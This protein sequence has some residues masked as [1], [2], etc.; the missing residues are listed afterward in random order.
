MHFRSVPWWTAELT[1][2]KKN[3][4]RARRRYQGTKDPAAREE[5]KLRYRK[6]RKEFTR[7]I[8]KAKEKSWRDF[9]TKEG[10]REPWGIPYKIISGKIRGE[11]TVSTLHTPQGETNNWRMTVAAMLSAILPDDQKGTDTPEQAAIR[12]SAETP[13]KLRTPLNS[14]HMS[15][16]AQLK[17]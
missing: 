13:P 16:L 3:T 2:A 17:G 15:S 1:R 12:Q 10:N 8:A 14:N 11:Q 4:H 5:E 9:V 6:I 7:M